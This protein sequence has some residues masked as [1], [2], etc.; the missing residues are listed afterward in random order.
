MRVGRQIT[1]GGMSYFQT[2]FLKKRQ[3][4]NP[5]CHIT[6]ASACNRDLR[7]NRMEGDTIASEPLHGWQLKTNQSKVAMEYLIWQESQISGRI[8]HVGNEGESRIPNSRFTVDG[9]DV[10][11]NTIYE[12]QGCFWH[13]CRKCYPN[14]SELHPRIEL[15]STVD[16]YLCTQEKLQ[17]LRD[18]RYHV[19]EMWECDWQ[20]M[21]EEREDIRNFVA[22]LDLAEPL[23]PRDA[24][25]G[26]RTNAIKLYH[27]AD[28]ASGKKINYYDFTSLYP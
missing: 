8:Q 14:R 3:K 1:E 28:I 12:F 9:Y 22:G 19:I 5:F 15:R 16:V 27:Q 23:N 6:I 10:A 18:R 13:G 2:F 20:K 26:G 4:F 25:C 11:T 24:F 7:Q 21:K 17:F